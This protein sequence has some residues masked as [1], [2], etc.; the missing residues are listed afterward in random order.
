ML[1][2][3]YISEYFHQREILYPA[4]GV[5]NRDT[6]WLIFLRLFA[7]VKDLHISKQFAFD[8][9]RVLQQLIRDRKKEVFPALRNLFL[10]D[11]EP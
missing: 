7:S 5:D 3:L 9:V 6:F 2:E 10:Q 1:E 11:D 4:V 8:V